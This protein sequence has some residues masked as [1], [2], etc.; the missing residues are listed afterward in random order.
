MKMRV[1]IVGTHNNN[2][3]QQVMTNVYEFKVIFQMIIIFRPWL[4]VQNASNGGE[5]IYGFGY[6]RLFLF[7]R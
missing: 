4:Q 3:N 1:T 5:W 7:I 2:N 6:Q